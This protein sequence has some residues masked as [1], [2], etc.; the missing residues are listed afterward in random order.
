MSWA[1]EEFR[2][3]DLGD[4][5]LNA[6]AVLLAER[7]GS[8]PGESIPNACS[9][10]AETQAAYRFLSN[11][12][13]D[14]QG[15]LQPHW[16]CSVERMRGHAV[17]LNIQDTTEL[18]FNAR[19]IAGLGPLSYEAQRG[20]Y[21]HPTYVITPDREPL[22][23]LDAWM[24]ARQP[25]GSDGQRGGVKES[26][27]WIDGYERVAERA[28]ELPEVRQ[29]Y[30][31]DREADILA[32]LLKAREWGHAAD[33]L[34]RCQHDRALPEGDKLWGRLSQAPVLGQVSFELPAGRG[35]QARRVRQRIR[36]QR[37]ELSD[38]AKGSLPVTCLLAEEVDAPAGAKPVLWRLLSNREV[39]TLEQ[40]VELI[41]WYR[42]R[43]E[44]E[45]FFLIL[46]E[47]LR[48]EALQLGQV[49][50]IETALALYLVVAWRLNRLMRLGRSLPDLP[51]QLLFDKDEWQ[52]A[53]VLNK[54]KP[55]EQQPSLNTVVRLVA[56]L[57][58]FL[59]RKGDG[60]PGAKTLWLGMRDVAV[61]VQGLRF[62]RRA[63]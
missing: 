11:P 50:R 53:Y 54:K 47:G 62:A 21:L 31:A 38:G 56:Q 40:A 37:I 48:I 57:G 15:V 58:G 14:W 49:Q 63:L 9:G 16:D 12:R 52:A 60:E 43:W 7:L 19:A 13:S 4:A 44:I 27:R 32:L 42:A 34:I 26:L 33:Y 41:E 10:W 22:G 55:P 8:K 18:D 3:L 1:E 20:M 5:R 61:F 6:R 25:K 39:R 36:V 17:V 45:L 35:R 2:T 51:A 23:V 28:Q 29:V 24:W 59:G 30:V 46:K